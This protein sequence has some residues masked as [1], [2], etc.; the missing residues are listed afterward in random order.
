MARLTYSGT[1]HDSKITGNDITIGPTFSK[2]ADPTALRKFFTLSVH[3]NYK[4]TGTGINKSSEWVSRVKLKTITAL[5]VGGEKEF[6]IATLG[7]MMIW[8]TK[9][10]GY[11][12]TKTELV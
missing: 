9:L 2:N 7:S 4:G 12:P 11:S 8:L 10:V 5:S 3:W 6:Y 1:N